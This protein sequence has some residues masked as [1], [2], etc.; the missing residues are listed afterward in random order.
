[1]VQAVTRM[2]FLSRSVR[3]L[4]HVVSLRSFTPTI[5]KGSKPQTSGGSSPSPRLSDLEASTE[6]G[7][8]R[9]K[10]EDP[11]A[12]FYEQAQAELEGEVRGQLY[13][14]AIYLMHD[15]SLPLLLGPRTTMKVIQ[16][17]MMKISSHHILLSRE[18]VIFVIL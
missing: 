2:S 4:P 6:P 5:P 1:M 7:S 11:F 8:L 14:V 15:T 3:L 12:K 18:S 16:G 17:L 9:L 10:K 13:S